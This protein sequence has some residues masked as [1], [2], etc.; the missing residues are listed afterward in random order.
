MN[1]NE[2]LIDRVKDLRE[3]IFDKLDDAIDVFANKLNVNCRLIFS[4]N[5]RLKTEE[6]MGNAVDDIEISILTKD[7]LQYF[8]EAEIN[9]FDERL[10]YLTSTQLNKFIKEFEAILDTIQFDIDTLKSYDDVDKLLEDK[11]DNNII[12]NCIEF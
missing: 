8:E 11:R 7:N 1:R 3:E 4:Y 5:N 2:E 6:S 12:F 10:E 9:S